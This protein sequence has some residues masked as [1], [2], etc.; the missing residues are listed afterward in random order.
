MQIAYET[1]MSIILIFDDTLV[2]LHTRTITL[3][4]RF[5][6]LCNKLG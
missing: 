5:W 3:V 2:Y 4:A 6:I 1:W